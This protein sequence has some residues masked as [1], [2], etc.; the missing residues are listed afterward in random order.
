MTKRH[1]HGVLKLSST[2]LDYV[3]ELVGLSLES[4]TEIDHLFHEVFEI[5]HQGYL[6][7]RWI[8]VVG[9]LRGVH[10]IQRMQL[11][12]VAFFEAQLLESSV[13]DN[14]VGVHVGGSSR[15]TLNSVHHELVV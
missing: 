10:V 2:H 12:V 3:A 4:F 9:R 13:G 1:W 14:L 15:A 7:G 6:N 5:N 8:H 11:V